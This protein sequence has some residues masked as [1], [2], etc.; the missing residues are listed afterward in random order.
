MSVKRKSA[1]LD[2]IK[3]SLPL[4]SILIMVEIVGGSMVHGMDHSAFPILLVM[5]PLLNGIGGDLGSVLGSRLS[6]ALHLGTLD[7]SFRDKELWDNVTAILFIALIVFSLAGVF[8]Y[9]LAPMI[10]ISLSG[11]S[12][13]IILKIMLMSGLMLT[14]IVVLLASL[15]AFASFKLGSDPDTFVIPIMTTGADF[16]GIVCLLIAT[17][18]VLP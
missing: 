10:G 5:V 2:L 4:L 14:G 7:P 18:M 3:E 1:V 13:W 11:L 9:I 16:L 12:F 8:V 6:S 17:W 15:V